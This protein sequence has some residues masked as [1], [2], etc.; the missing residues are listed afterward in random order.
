MAAALRRGYQK[1]RGRERM[2][3]DQHL[4][5]EFYAGLETTIGTEE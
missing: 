5:A 3:V 1:M 4:K 2:G